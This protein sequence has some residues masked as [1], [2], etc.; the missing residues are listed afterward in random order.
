MLQK[1][2]LGDEKVAAF[3]LEGAF[4]EKGFKQSMIQFLPEL[5]MRSK[6]NLYLEVVNLTQVEAKA[7]WEE[8]KYDV[9]NIGQLIGKIDKVALVT[10]LNWMRTLASTSSVLV[11]GIVVK[12]FKFE[13]SDAARA[14]VK[15]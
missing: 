4:D 5:Q 13:E 3:R 6:M 2:E 11:P 12:T 7:F 14:F 15:E 9:K 10:D 1:L 8:I